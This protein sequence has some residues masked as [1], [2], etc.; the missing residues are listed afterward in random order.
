MDSKKKLASVIFFIFA[1]LILSRIITF[2]KEPLFLQKLKDGVLAVFTRKPKAR[3]TTRLD[4]SL[5]TDKHLRERA[6]N[7]LRAQEIASKLYPNESFSNYQLA[8]AGYFIKQIEEYGVNMADPENIKLLRYLIDRPAEVSD[9]ADSLVNSDQGSLS[10]EK[11]NELEKTLRSWCSKQK[12]S[13][14]H[15]ERVFELLRQLSNKHLQYGYKYSYQSA[16]ERT[17]ALNPKLHEMVEIV[18]NP[19]LL[20]EELSRETEIFLKDDDWEKWNIKDLYIIGS[21]ARETIH[22]QSDV[23]L[24]PV[25]SKD[26][27]ETIKSTIGTQIYVKFGR[28]EI[29]ICWYCKEIPKNAIKYSKDLNLVELLGEASVDDLPPIMNP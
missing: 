15:F 27:P 4:L 25:F 16:I 10:N 28:E 19:P 12:L 23:D 24:A 1:G 22:P 6:K 18:K 9:L 5:I 7:A 11:S 8:N 14:D 17:I 20:K 26:T 3:E 13:D 21:Y 29:D 2:K